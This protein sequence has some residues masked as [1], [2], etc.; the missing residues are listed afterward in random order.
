MPDQSPILSIPFILPAQAQKH[1]THNEAVRLLDVL[2]QLV[3]EDR[4]RTAPPATVDDGVRHIVGSGA[5][6]D[7]TGRDGQIAVMEDGGWTFI[8][9]QEGWQAYVVAEAQMA[10]FDGAVWVGA[11][12][13][14]LQT[15]SL[16]IGAM[17][18]AMN[19]LA[20]SSPAVLLNHDG[21][22]MQLKLNK[23]TAAETASLLFQTGFSGRA[24]M[25]T[26]GGDGFQIKVSPDGSVFF[27]ALEAEAATGRVLA[28]N[29]VQVDGA[30]TGSGVVGIV[31]QVAGQSTGAVMEQGSGP[32]GRYLRFADGTQICTQ[33]ALSAANASTALGALFQSPVVGWTFPA[34]FVAPPVVT[35]LAETGGAWVV[36]DG[37]GTAV[38]AGF[39]VLSA[40]SVAGAVGFSA[41]AVGRWA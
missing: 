12:E 36:R 19:R 14:V 22:G 32:G 38:A 10:V 25:G 21:A 26:V 35:A 34:A 31:A 11:G 6:G 41:V 3:V 5:A 24:E 18:D 27:T 9:P 39:R 37:A 33:N 1:V 8:A 4:D 28:P 30:L 7:W 13:G 17:P 2:V 15:G 29:G 23:A 20:V 16:G 40:T